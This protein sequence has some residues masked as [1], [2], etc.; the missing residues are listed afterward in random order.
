ME[1][2]IEG[3]QVKLADK[4]S[5]LTTLVSKQLDS[6]GEAKVSTLALEI[7]ELRADILETKTK[8]YGL[9]LGK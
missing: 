4:R 6:N 5:N 1:K 7:S 3:L 2:E 8:L 9:M